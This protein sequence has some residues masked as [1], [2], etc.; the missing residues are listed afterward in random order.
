MACPGSVDK[1]QAILRAATWLFAEAGL[2]APTARIAQ[3]AGVRAQ[4][5]PQ[6]ASGS[7]ATFAPL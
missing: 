5:Y 2:N 1:R 4:G 7:R 6:G 3:T